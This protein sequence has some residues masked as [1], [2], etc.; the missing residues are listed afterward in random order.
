MSNGQGALAEAGLNVDRPRTGLVRGPVADLGVKS[1]NGAKGTKKRT[2]HGV[3][4]PFEEWVKIDSLIEGRFMEMFLIGSLDKTFAERRDHLRCILHHGKSG[5]NLGKMP[6]GIVTDLHADSRAGYYEVELF[7][8]L[9][10]VLLEGLE[11]GQYGT[12]VYYELVKADERF[13]PGRSSYNPEGL[14]ELRIVEAKI[15]EFGPTPFP[16]YEGAPAGLRSMTDD[17][18]MAQLAEDPERLAQLVERTGISLS[19]VDLNPEHVAERNESAADEE[20]RVTRRYERACE[21]VQTAVWLMHPT[22]LAKIAM[23]V[24]ERKRGHRPDAEEIAERIGERSEPSAV[25]ED[26]SVAVLPLRGSI[27]PRADMFSDISGGASITGFQQDFRAA[28]ADESVTSI[29]MDVDSPGGSSE[30]VEELATEIRDARGTKPIV[31][32][33]NTWAASAAYYLAAQADE[34]VVTPSGEVG[35]IGAYRMH[36]DI[37]S[38]QEKLGVDTTLISA[39]KYKVEGNPF[40][41]LGDEAEAELQEK[42]DATYKMFVSAVAKGRGVPVKTVEADFGQG[43]MVMAAKAVE[44]GMADRVATFDQTLARLEKLKPTAPM[45]RAAALDEPEPEPEPSEAT[46]QVDPSR[47]TRQRNYLERRKPKWHL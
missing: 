33:A 40:E 39:G 3:M 15:I 8:D 20:P 22:A 37:S 19:E 16:I 5:T 25:S 9:P 43:R 27:I 13:H 36:A 46:T 28:L 29:L 11:T 1:A 21:F 12:S 34:L 42:V 45:A 24:G 35:S 23:I 14:D 4:V 18:L 7:D 44:L 2:L 6:I 30:L 41:P 32:V 10:G 26:S 38:M 47:R 17:A 31:A